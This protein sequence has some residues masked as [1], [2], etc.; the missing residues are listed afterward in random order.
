MC[1]NIIPNI[2]GQAKRGDEDSFNRD[3][4]GRGQDGSSA[5]HIYNIHGS[6]GEGIESREGAKQDT[7]G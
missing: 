1:K 3:E 6:S 4:G 2:W 7:A 5:W